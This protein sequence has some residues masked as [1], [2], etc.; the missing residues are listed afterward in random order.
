ML[1]HPC[2]WAVAAPLPSSP[3]IPPLLIT[4]HHHSTEFTATSPPAETASK[5]WVE[6]SR[7][8]LR[9]AVYLSLGAS[10]RGGLSP[11]GSPGRLANGGGRSRRPG[12]LLDPLCL[13]PLLASASPRRPYL[14]TSAPGKTHVV[15][16]RGLTGVRCRRHREEA[17]ARAAPW[18]CSSAA[19]WAGQ[20]RRRVLRS[21]AQPL[22]R[23]FAA[24]KSRGLRDG[25]A[26]AAGA[27]PPGWRVL[28]PSPAQPCGRRA[29]LQPGQPP[30]LGKEG[31][32]GGGGG[33]SRAQ[34]DI[35]AEE[36]LDNAEGKPLT[37]ADV[38]S[39]RTR[40]DLGKPQLLPRA[41]VQLWP[42]GLVLCSA[43]AVRHG[44]QRVLVHL[45]C[46]RVL[47]HKACSKAETQLSRH[48]VASVRALP[49]P[50]LSDC[51]L[52]TT[53]SWP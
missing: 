16:R 13:P 47:Q 34:M 43:P 31:F 2:G 53:I 38:A 52:P 23:L 17:A 5:G 20:E 10:C 32:S 7:G 44:F 37:S 21:A 22:E 25:A 50:S 35:L 14:G 1:M 45:S 12:S 40:R 36:E 8:E 51:I 41:A 11:S 33:S 27:G 39:S 30:L 15:E 18:S 28:T 4:T 48:G 46:L 3:H 24:A 49:Q 6:K 19:C 9:G 29:L 42:L 26:A